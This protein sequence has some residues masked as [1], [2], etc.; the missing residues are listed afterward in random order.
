MSDTIFA[1]A[2]AAG[3]SGVAIVRVSGPNAL[4]AARSITG[5]T[6]VPR[7]AMLAMLSARDGSTID[8]ALVLYFENDKSFTGEPVVEFQTHGSGPVV[9]K[10]LSE[11]ELIEGLRI[12]EPGEFTRRALLNGQMDLAQVEGLADL[13]E[14]ET[15]AQRLQAQRVF[16]G[17]LGKLVEEWRTKLICAA[18]LIEATIDFAD[19]EVPVDVAP[20]VSELL[21]DVRGQLRE[22]EQG[23]KTAER[24]RDGF[25][26]AIVGPPNV[27]KSTL[28]NSIAGRD[29]ALT[30]EYAGTTRDFIEVRMDLEGLPV[31]F[32][33]TA[34]LRESDDHVEALGIERAR[35]RADRADVRVFLVERAGAEPE[36]KPKREDLVLVSKADLG[37]VEG[38]SVSG[39]SGQGVPELLKRIGAILASRASSAGLSTRERHRLALTQA[40]G[41]LESAL[42][43]V[44]S[45]PDR[46]DLAAEEIRTAL[47]ALETLLGR[48]HVE[49]LLDEIFSSFCI[50]K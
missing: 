45:G 37:D 35:T 17:E 5:M 6:P 40:I 27:G 7:R 28:L 10:L 14:A 2:T 25:E 4:Q 36:L 20:E 9:S 1:A 21:I 11:L 50:G 44:K 18:A 26:V 22:H 43:E 3:K 31:T 32:L 16:S 29:A 49:S 46:A 15:E 47:R 34:G 8:E 23:T 33:D 38:P 12:A 39:K 30:S 42:V 48:V 19:E 13:I 41:A 24:I